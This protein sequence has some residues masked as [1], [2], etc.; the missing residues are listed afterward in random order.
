MQDADDEHRHRAD[1]GG[2]G[3]GEDASVDTADDEA[4]YEDGRPGQQQGADEGARVGPLLRRRD[5][6]VAAGHDQNDDGVEHDRHQ[7]RDHRGHEQLGDVLLG[8]DGVDDEDDRGRDQKIDHA[9]DGDERSREAVLVA[10]AAQLRQRGAAEGCGGRDGG[11]ADGAEDGAGAEHRD[12]EPAADMPHEAARGGEQIAGHARLLGERAHEDEQRNDGEGIVRELLVGVRLHV[13]EER[14]EARQVAV[15]EGADHQHGQP[16]RHAYGDQQQH[17]AEADQG[18]R[19]SAHDC[20]RATC[21]AVTIA[22]SVIKPE[23]TVHTAM[24]GQ[25]I[26]CSIIVVSP[27]R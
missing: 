19:H 13:G 25:T 3:R 11:T 14:A 5:R 22:T 26:N 6:G 17:R 9:A 27:L 12:A 20:P 21:T 2:F 24:A 15:A 1:G 8:G 7:A 16:Y 18:N 10:V 4:Q 23:R